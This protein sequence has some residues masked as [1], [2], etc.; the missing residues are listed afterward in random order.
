MLGSLPFFEG[1]GTA[2]T[3]TPAGRP[4]RVYDDPV[5]TGPYPEE[6]SRRLWDGHSF[7]LLDLV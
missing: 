1:A 6:A 2:D 4:T 7:G 5:T 3:P